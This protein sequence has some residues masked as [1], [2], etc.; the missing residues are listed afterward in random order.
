MNELFVDA[1]YVI[2][3]IG[4]FLPLR[5][6]NYL[7]KFKNPEHNEYIPYPH[8]NILNLF[9]TQHILAHRLL[10]ILL[11]VCGTDVNDRTCTDPSG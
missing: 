2:A 5:G 8:T 4:R 11:V 1:M 7:S 10:E 6:F 3:E 9:D